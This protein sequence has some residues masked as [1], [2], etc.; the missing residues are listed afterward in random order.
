MI[1]KLFAH[2]SQKSYSIKSNRDMAIDLEQLQ[3]RYGR[4]SC[5]YITSITFDRSDII[6]DPNNPIFCDIGNINEALEQIV[7]MSNN[8]YTGKYISEHYLKSEKPYNIANISPLALTSNDPNI[9]TVLSLIYHNNILRM[10][11]DNH[12][13]EH[14]SIDFSAEDYKNNT[15]YFDIPS[16][17]RRNGG[18]WY[19]K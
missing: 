16:T 10:T 12:I 7:S 14:I 3:L 4:L 5:M 8:K 19:E 15:I 18:V 6:L 11:S 1:P 9:V 2:N 13:I 17:L